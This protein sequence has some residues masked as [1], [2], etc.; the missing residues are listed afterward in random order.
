MQV[1]LVD[2]YRKLK[3]KRLSGEICSM[4]SLKRE[5]IGTVFELESH[6]LLGRGTHCSLVIHSKYASN[7]HLSLDW[8]DNRWLVKDLG[9]TNGTF[10]DNVPVKPRNP[11]ACKLGQHICVGEIGE[12]WKLV[13]ASPPL[14]MIVSMGSDERRAHVIEHGAIVLPSTDNPDISI[15]SDNNDKWILERGG[16]REVLKPNQPFSACNCVW[17]L[18]VPDMWQYTTRK[19]NHL[20]IRESATTFYVSSDEETV[21]ICVKVGGEEIWIP[22]RSHN[23]MLLTLARE[24]LDNN[25]C[26]GWV[27]STLLQKKLR[28]N[29]CTINVWIYRARKSFSEH[30]FI[31]PAGIVERQDGAIRIGCTGLSVKSLNE[32]RTSSSF[33]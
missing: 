19:E 3:K 16:N 32:K 23:Y 18:S 13:D 2:H 15:Y 31:A 14:P 6:N 33:I 11:R 17:R 1:T 30:G 4:G 5:D 12:R 24:R 25:P 8:I 29:E 7:E 10:I 26:G 20:H 27:D 22:N 28:V 9:T 21:E